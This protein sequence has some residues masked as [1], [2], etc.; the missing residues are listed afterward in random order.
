MAK[1][2]NRN[3]HNDPFDSPNMMSWG[4]DF[5]SVCNQHCFDQA[6]KQMDEEFGCSSVPHILTSKKIK[7]LNK[8][9]FILKNID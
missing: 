1:C 6:R 5:D 8:F 4:S 2:V 9:D 3:C 7:K